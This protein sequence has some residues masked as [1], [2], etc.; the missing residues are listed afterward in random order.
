MRHHADLLPREYVLFLLFA[1]LVLVTGIFPQLV[2]DFSGPATAALL[3]SIL[4]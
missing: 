1:L 4:G 2:L 3:A